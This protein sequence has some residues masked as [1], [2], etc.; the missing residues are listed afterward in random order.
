MWSGSAEE[1]L[2][3]ENGGAEGSPEYGRRTVT[4]TSIQGFGRPMRRLSPP[5]STSNVA[6]ITI[7]VPCEGN[8]LSRSPADTRVARRFDEGLRRGCGVIF[9]LESRTQDDRRAGA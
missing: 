1:N 4:P 2:T 8:R 5:A 7:S 9:P 6:S 3:S